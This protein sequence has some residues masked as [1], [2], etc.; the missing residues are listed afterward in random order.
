MLLTLTC[1]QREVVRKDRG[2][3][4][5]DG[6]ADAN[7]RAHGSTSNWQWAI[8][9]ERLVC[10]RTLFVCFLRRW[11]LTLLLLLIVVVVAPCSWRVSI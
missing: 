5:V 4:R 7:A 11:F 3:Q 10:G 6:D 2:A 8:D 1:E 9:M